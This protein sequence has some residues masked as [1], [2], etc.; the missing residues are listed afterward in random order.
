MNFFLLINVKV[1]TIVGILTLMSRV[2]NQLYYMKQENSFD[3]DYFNIYVLLK[4]HT[5]LSI[6]KFY[7]LGPSTYIEKMMKT[8]VMSLRQVV[9]FFFVGF[10]LQQ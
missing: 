1:S 9:L 6:K 8:A 2:N 10:S 3:S 7:N 4:F 5:Q